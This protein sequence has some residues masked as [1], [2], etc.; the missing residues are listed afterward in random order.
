MKRVVVLNQ[1]ALPRS[2]SGGTRHVDLFGRLTDW[3]PL[4]VAGHR[5]HYSQQVYSTTDERFQLLRVPRSTAGISRVIGWGTY[6]F[7]AFVLVLL[8]PNLDVVFG[9]TPH[10]FA[11]LAGLLAARIRRV[12]F[13]LEVRDLWPESLV[14]A[15]KIRSGGAM[16]KILSGLERLL[17][18]KSDL[19]VAVTAGWQEHFAELGM[20]DNCLIVVPNGTELGD[21][22]VAAS[23]EE[24]RDSL[25]IQGFTAV[26]AGAHGPKDGIDLILDA[27]GQLPRVNFILVGEGSAKSAAVKRAKDEFLT[28]V[29]FRRPVA[30]EDL[31]GLLKACDVG[32]HCVSPLPVFDQGMS[33][34]KLFDY[35]A[36]GLPVVSNAEQALSG[37]GV[38]GEFGHFGNAASLVDSLQRVLIASPRTRS[39]WG[40]NGLRL[41]G[42][43]F[44]RRQAAGQLNEVLNKISSKAAP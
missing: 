15:G 41:V 3:E 19:I 24:L 25:S 10:L 42:E 12:P 18:R 29:D 4:I 34:N 5:N 21:F 36:S 32:I 43:R 7:Q 28:N 33:P 31:P 8:R 1:F 40:R 23:K 6:A 14:D 39:A 2:E 22:E 26:F 20:S 27:A 30:K 11:P 37:I 17:V 44:S 38:T 9:S 35:M 13:V 16:H